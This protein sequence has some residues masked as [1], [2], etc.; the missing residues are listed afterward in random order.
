M[1]ASAFCHHDTVSTP[2]SPQLPG[3]V[4]SV[5][6]PAHDEERGIG[7]LLESLL[8]DSAPGEIEVIVACNAC[9]DRTAEVARRLGPD[10]TV[11]ESEI[12]SKRLAQQAGDAVA[13]VFPRAYVDAD[14]VLTTADLRR[15]AAPLLE[16][17]VLA[18]APARRLVGLDSS[19]VVRHYYALW[20]RLPQV[21]TG[22]FGRGVVMVS[23]EG[24]ARILDLPQLLSDDLVMSEAFTPQERL[25]VDA[26]VV[27]ISLPRTTRDLL[28]RRVRVATG[29][30]QV[31]Q[32]HLRAPASTTSV[33]TLVRIAARDPRAVVDLSVF[34]AVTTVAKVRAR[35]RVRSGDYSTWLRDESSRA[36]GP[37]P[38]GGR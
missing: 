7:R 24:A 18:T 32:M 1:G 35:R 20:E 19:W 17:R 23:Q 14:V 33:G 37:P 38:T 2:S 6:I 27:E 29:T 34:L 11:L 16:A 13:T 8:R 9:T 3:P 5:V 10:V 25:V 30:A 26:A 15:L 28:N 4:L 31:D 12:A 21:R 36:A 22:L